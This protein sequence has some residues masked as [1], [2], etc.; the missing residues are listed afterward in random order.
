VPYLGDAQAV[1]FCQV[2]MVTE[3]GTHHI[4]VGEIQQVLVS[5]ERVSPLLY[6]N[7]GYGLLADS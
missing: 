7:G 4:V 6:I 3:Y 1:F 2:D 5:E